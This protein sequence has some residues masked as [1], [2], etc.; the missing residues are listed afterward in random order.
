M[1]S[2]RGNS[3]KERQFYSSCDLRPT[4]AYLDENWPY[5]PDL[6]GVA[7]GVSH[8]LKQIYQDPTL[9]KRFRLNESVETKHVFGCGCLVSKDEVEEDYDDLKS[10]DDDNDDSNTEVQAEA[11]VGEL[12]FSHSDKMLPMASSSS[13]PLPSPSHLLYFENIFKPPN[14]DQF[15]AFNCTEPGVNL[16]EDTAA[17]II[18][19]KKPHRLKLS[20]VKWKWMKSSLTIEVT[21]SRKDVASS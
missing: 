21:M 12:S 3:A 1:S 5:L 2:S 9:R 17:F 6:F 13:L 18:E 20:F 19:T 16:K 15:C 4:L 7:S 10:D 11:E 14:Y 8:V